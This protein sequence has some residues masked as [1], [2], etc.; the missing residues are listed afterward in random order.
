MLSST[1]CDSPWM[2][3]TVSKHRPFSFTYNLGNKSNF[4]SL[5]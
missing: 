3:D 4:Y 5:L 1:A 2:L